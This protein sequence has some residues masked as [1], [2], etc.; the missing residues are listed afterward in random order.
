MTGTGFDSKPTELRV[1]ADGKI[2]ALGNFNSYNGT[3]RAKIARLNADGSLDGSFTPSVS[4]ANSIELQPDGK[5]LV[6][7]GSMGINGF[8]RTGVARLNSNGT[9][10]ATFNPVISSPTV[11]AAVVQTDGK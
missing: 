3:A 4:N 11:W 9:L 2:L 5:I 8:G 7:G 10:D 6:L 1:Q